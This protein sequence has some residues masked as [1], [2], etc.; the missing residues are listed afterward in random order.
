MP[1]KTDETQNIKI[2]KLEGAMTHLEKGLDE[3]KSNFKEF[4]EKNDK[5]H[6]DITAKIDK[7]IDAADERYASKEVEKAMWWLIFAVG[8]AIIGIVVKL[9]AK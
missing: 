3:I 6:L 7:F 8:T 9:I 4:D 1:P 5:A 2:T